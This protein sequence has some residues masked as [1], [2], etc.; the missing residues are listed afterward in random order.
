MTLSL[1]PRSL[2]AL[3]ALGLAAC[4][5]DPASSNPDAGTP[6]ADA[7]TGA[8]D[9]STNLDTTCD[10]D[11]E[12]ASACGGSPVGTWTYVKACSTEDP[13]TDL[14][15]ACGGA[16]S[17]NIAYATGGTLTL[18]SDG[19]FTRSSND[20]VTGDIAVPA[21][22]ALLAG[23]CTGITS[24]IEIAGGDDTTA[25]CTS[26]AGGG[27]DCTVSDVLAVDDTGVWV[28][29]EGTITVTGGL[30]SLYW[31]CA[32]NGV[33]KYRGVEGNPDRISYVLTR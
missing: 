33:L 4:G 12:M 8:A 22:C 14:V 5:S 2:T 7:S 26:N 18:S 28:E 24:A 15:G 29:S 16:T 21:S 3:L 10:P 23:G 25:T 6:G 9:A 27:C 13:F 17:S 30:V 19:T 32:G 20:T 11:F 1:H 31:Y